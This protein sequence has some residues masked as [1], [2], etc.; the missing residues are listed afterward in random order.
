MW[1][2]QQLHRDREL[3]PGYLQ[4]HGFQPLHRFHSPPDHLHRA[5]LVTKT[6]ARVQPA[7]PIDPGVLSSQLGSG[8]A[9]WLRPVSYQLRARETDRPEVE[10]GRDMET[11]SF[12]SR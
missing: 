4:K 3:R 9:V 2:Q 6:P 10:Q 7:C 5:L 8:R 12:H 11:F 1:P